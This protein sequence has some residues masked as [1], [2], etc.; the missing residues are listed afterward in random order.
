MDIKN[1]TVAQCRFHYDP[2]IGGKPKQ[3]FALKEMGP[4]AHMELTPIGV[5][6]KLWVGVGNDKTMQ[7]HVVPYANTQSIMLAR[8][9]E[10]SK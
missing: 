7:E 6:V 5:Y 1:R 3:A 4:G 2:M 9:E 10:K 8:E